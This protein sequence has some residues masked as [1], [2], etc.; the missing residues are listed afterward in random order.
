MTPKLSVIVPFRNAVAQLPVLLN[1]LERQVASRDVFEVIWVDDASG[2]H[3]GAWLQQHLQPGWRLLV[4]PR[5]R[6]SYAARNTGL[7]AA[8]GDNLAFIDVDCRPQEDWIEQG[9]ACLASAP[10]V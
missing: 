10:R 1:A 4:H 2:D 3:G 7:H 6:G 9:L 5:P 8:A